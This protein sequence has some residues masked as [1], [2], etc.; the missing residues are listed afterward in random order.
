MNLKQFRFFLILLSVALVIAG[1]GGI[2]DGGV[3]SVLQ[4]GQ[5]ES[6]ISGGQS[7]AGQSGDVSLADVGYGPYSVTG[8]EGGFLSVEGTADGILIRKENPPQDTVVMICVWEEGVNGTEYYNRMFFNGMTGSLNGVWL[9]DI[10]PSGFT[11]DQDEFIYR[12]TRKD[13]VYGVKMQTWGVASNS[14]WI[15]QVVSDTLYV[16]AGGGI[17]DFR[18]I[19]RGSRY[20]HAAGELYFDFTE[21]RPTGLDGTFRYEM[22]VQLTDGKRFEVLPWGALDSAI[23]GFNLDEFFYAPD[24]DQDTGSKEWPW[25][26]SSVSGE[27]KDAFSLPQIIDASGGTFRVAYNFEYTTADF[28]Y[29]TG[30]GEIYNGSIMATDKKVYTAY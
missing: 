15:N 20:D 23:S 16:R 4:G 3:G 13:A 22:D 27:N 9:N 7:N 24:M 19:V 6:S 26:N 28:D 1:C 17:G 10:V 12:F 18:T 5:G 8:P 14:D 25:W 30:K 21:E 2:F 29:K 11:N